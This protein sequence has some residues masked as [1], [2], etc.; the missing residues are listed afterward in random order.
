MYIATHPYQNHLLEKLTKCEFDRL[1]PNLE[2]VSLALGQIMYESGEKPHYVYFPASGIISLL[3]VMEN[4][5]SAE[6]A[7]VGNEGILGITVFMGGGST[8]IRAVVQSAGS[9]Y[10]IKANI[11]LT[12]FNLAGPL[13][14]F[15]LRYTQ[16][17]MTQM[18]QT[19]AC[20]RH[21]T[22]DQQLCRWLL[23]S[24]DRLNGDTLYMT[25]E[26]IA[27]MLG[28]RREGVTEAACKLQSSGLIKYSRGKITIL[29]RPNLEKRCCECYAVVKT[30]FDKLM[31]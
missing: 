23:L 27:N 17:L 18:A 11:L 7:V 25:Q 14:H 20:N 3:N 10:R 2:L 9:S 22:I 5:A 16:A 19:A 30:E 29:D 15:L 24:F 13:Q 31:N 4:G 26:L 21:H 8:P 1:S 6:I 12:E 28:V